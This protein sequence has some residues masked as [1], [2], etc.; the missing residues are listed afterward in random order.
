[1][2]VLNCLNELIRTYKQ[3]YK[4]VLRGEGG[5]RSPSKFSR[6][7]LVKKLKVRKKNCVRKSD[8]NLN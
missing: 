6:N 2:S 7:C 5:E 8:V 1:M 3:L 4:V